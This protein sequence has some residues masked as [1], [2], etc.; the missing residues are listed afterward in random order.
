[1]RLSQE[2]GIDKR[3]K[4]ARSISFYVPPLKVGGKKL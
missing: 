3:K 2:V 1:M 4:D